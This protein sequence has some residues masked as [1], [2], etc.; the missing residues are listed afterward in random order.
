MLNRWK[1]WF[2]VKMVKKEAFFTL[3]GE[4]IKAVILFSAIS[5]GLVGTEQ[6]GGR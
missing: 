5:G 3:F 4:T 6:D 2:V 1:W